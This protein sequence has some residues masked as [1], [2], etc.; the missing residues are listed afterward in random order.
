MIH[1]FSENF[2][3][4][5]LFSYCKFNAS[6]SNVYHLQKR[7]G[8][9]T[10]VDTD[11]THLS[12]LASVPVLRSDISCFEFRSCDSCRVTVQRE[13]KVTNCRCNIE[14]QRLPV[15][16]YHVVVHQLLPY[17]YLNLAHLPS[18]LYSVAVFCC[19]EQPRIE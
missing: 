19:N 10:N 4:S 16:G 5:L 1:F 11:G 13:A 17:S 2:K 7:R 14:Y 8:H 6:R 9:H 12:T 15:S 3:Y 18:C